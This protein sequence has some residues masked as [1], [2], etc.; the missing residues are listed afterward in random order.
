MSLKLAP[1]VAKN[2]VNRMNRR[3]IDVRNIKIEPSL[4]E[5]WSKFLKI[6]NHTLRELH[7]KISRP[8]SQR[9][10]LFFRCEQHVIFHPKIAKLHESVAT[11]TS[12]FILSCVD[13]Q[14]VQIKY[15]LFMF[16]LFSRA[17]VVVVSVVTSMY[18]YI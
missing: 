15:Y 4:T 14:I 17:G 2:I 12:Y 7:T 13:Q 1:R 9:H 3:H 6:Q 16:L 8:F 18:V 10:K 5:S 11:H